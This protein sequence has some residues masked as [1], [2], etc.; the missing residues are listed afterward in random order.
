MKG[1]R[2]IYEITASNKKPDE[3]I[4]YIPVRQSKKKRRL[5]E[6]FIEIML[7]QKRKTR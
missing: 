5:V 1:L 4:I 6:E 2:E 3:I 7:E